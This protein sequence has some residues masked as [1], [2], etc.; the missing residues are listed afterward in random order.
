MRHGG[1]GVVA[2]A[3][4]ADDRALRDRAAPDYRDRRKLEQRH[5]VSVGGLDRQ[6]ATAGRNGTRERDRA[7]GRGVNGLAGCRADVDPAVLA[8]RVLVLREREGPQDRPRGR[9]GP[10]GRDRDDDQGRDRNDDRDGEHAPH[11]LPPS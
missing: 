9:P 7:R 8:G 1:D 6:R 10:A 3:D 11:E 5:R 2:L 4:E